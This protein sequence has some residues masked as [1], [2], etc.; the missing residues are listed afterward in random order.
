MAELNRDRTA[1]LRGGLLAEAQRWLAERR[2]DLD[3]PERE[4]IEASIT[5]LKRQKLS[6]FLML[7]TY[8]FVFGLLTHVMAK[9]MR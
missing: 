2:Q 9:W 3:A 5:N 7:T 4:F 1:L 8:A 6:I